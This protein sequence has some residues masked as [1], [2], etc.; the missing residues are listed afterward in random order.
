[1]ESHTYLLSNAKVFFKGHQLLIASLC[2]SLFSEGVLL[3]L[4]DL[5]PAAQRLSKAGLTVMPQGDTMQVLA[6]K[7]GSTAEKLGI[8]Q[9]FR[10][11]SIE[12]PAD[13]PDKEWMFLPAL[14]LLFGVMGLQRARGRREKPLPAAGEPRPG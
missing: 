1:M 7:F 6:V 3:P 10:I 5:A 14:A 13:R 4:G 12:V 2:F 11:T 8:E 9:G